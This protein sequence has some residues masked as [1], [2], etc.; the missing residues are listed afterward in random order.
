MRSVRMST[1]R[2]RMTLMRILI[3]VPRGSMI[4]ATVL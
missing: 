3:V 2:I 1:T 4:V